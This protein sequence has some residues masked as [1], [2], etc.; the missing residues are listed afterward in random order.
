MRIMVRRLIHFFFFYII[1]TAQ[2]LYNRSCY[3]TDLDITRSCCGS[4]LFLPW[5]L[6]RNSW[7]MTIKWSFSY[8]VK[9]V[10][11]GHSKKDWKLVFQNQL[12]LNAGQ[13]YCW[14][15]QGEHSAI[16]STFVKLTFVI[17]IFFVYFWVAVLHRLYC[18]SFLKLSHYNIIHL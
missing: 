15:L 10:K 2:C 9:P 4:Q 11:N 7:K 8:T 14:M 17:K 3:N 1:E 16:L 18:N 6:Q 12:L 13:K 5:N